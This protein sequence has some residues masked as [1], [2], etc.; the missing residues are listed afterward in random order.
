MV[1]LVGGGGVLSSSLMQ[2][3]NMKSCIE[4]GI[5]CAQYGLIVVL[6]IKILLS[7]KIIQW[8]INIYTKAT[9]APS[10]WKIIG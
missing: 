6:W 3:L 8:S 4:G 10:L 1:I 5:V 7:P 2:D 9:I